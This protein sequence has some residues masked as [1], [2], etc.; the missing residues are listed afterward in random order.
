MSRYYPGKGRKG[1]GGKTLKVPQTL[2]EPIEQII[3]LLRLKAYGETYIEQNSLNPPTL[4]TTPTEITVPK[5]L[6]PYI[7]QIVDNTTNVQ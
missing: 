5:Y 1:L 7:K 2:L 3:Q 4:D 6:Q